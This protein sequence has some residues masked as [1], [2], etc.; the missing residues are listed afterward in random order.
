M[1]GTNGYVSSG[2]FQNWISSGEL[3]PAI[4]ISSDQ[5]SA[6]NGPMGALEI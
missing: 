1:N 4:R 2:I 3:V 6:I 5:G